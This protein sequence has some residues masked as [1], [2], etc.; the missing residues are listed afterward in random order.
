MK[1]KV[2]REKHIKHIVSIW[3]GYYHLTELE[4]SLL[5]SII[6]H[7]TTLKENIKDTSLI[8]KNFLD[9]AFK[10]ELMEKYSMKPPQLTNYLNSLIRKKVLR[11]EE[12]YSL[13]PKFNL[14]DKL[15]FEFIYE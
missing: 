4:V 15:T 9:S 14:V 10:K 13:D 5:C 11:R 6:E 3:N 7:Y 1:I 8:N 2:N 12:F